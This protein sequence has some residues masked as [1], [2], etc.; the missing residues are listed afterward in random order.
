MVLGAGK[1]RD[2]A[3]VKEGGVGKGETALC[4]AVW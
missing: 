2:G 3:G 4:E 1:G